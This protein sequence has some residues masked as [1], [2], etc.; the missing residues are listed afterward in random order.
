MQAALA[1][2]TWTLAVLTL[3]AL[4]VGNKNESNKIPTQSV[5]QVV[6]GTYRQLHSKFVILLHD[7]TENE[8]REYPTDLSSL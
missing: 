2:A 3:P 6:I 7:S 8:E 4:A 1:L 5:A